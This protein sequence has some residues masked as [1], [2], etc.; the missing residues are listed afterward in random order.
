MLRYNKGESPESICRS[1]GCSRSWLYKWVNRHDSG[2]TEWNQAYSRHP[3]NSPW[4]T[5]QE[6]EEVVKFVRLN[7]YDIIGTINSRCPCLSHGVGFRASTQPTI[8]F[9]GFGAGGWSLCSCVSNFSFAARLLERP[10]CYNCPDN[11]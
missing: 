2:N 11:V 4:R 6:I 8:T 5:S 7:L 3:K 1:L 9:G 10:E